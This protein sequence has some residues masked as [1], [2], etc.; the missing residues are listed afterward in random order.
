[1]QKFSSIN[2]EKDDTNI[3]QE[4]ST[5]DTEN[6]ISSE[7]VSFKIEPVFSYSP[8]PDNIKS[9]MLGL[10]MPKSE[11][12]SFDSLSYLRLT[13][14]GFDGNIHIGEMVVNKDIASDV[15]DA[16]KEVYYKKYPIEKIR[17]IDEYNAD[18]E[19][20]M[21][22]NN[23]SSFAYRTIKGTNVISN[24]GMGL[25]IDINPLQ[26]PHVVGN[27]ASPKEGSDYIDRSNIRKGMIT[28]GDDL[29]NAF[30][31]RGFSWGG[32]WKNPDYQHFEKK[33]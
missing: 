19:L 17:L 12:I 21:A 32:H 28:E 31:N 23:T 22:D 6:K 9:K 8:I 11:P 13:Y 15:V 29:Y 33:L 20:S 24:H 2:L 10:S 26:N 7:D 1:M 14:Y 5:L 18:D 27:T 16:F 25:A 30:V 3:K 4:T